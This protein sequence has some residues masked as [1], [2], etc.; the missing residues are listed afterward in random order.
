MKIKKINQSAG[1]VANV[2]DSLT[3]N[4]TTDALSAKQG[5]IL[6]EKIENI[7]VSG[8][9]TSIIDVDTLPAITDSNKNQIVRYQHKLYIAAEKYIGTP[10]DLGVGA[11][12]SSAKLVLS[13]PDTLYA[14]GYAGI[15]TLTFIRTE[16]SAISSYN[17]STNNYMSCISIGTHGLYGDKLY[18][19]NTNTQ[20]VAINLKSYIM[21]ANAGL[22]TEIKTLT[23]VTSTGFYANLGNYIKYIPATKVWL[24]IDS[25]IAIGNEEP[26]GQEVL[27]IDEDEVEE[28]DIDIENIVQ[29][30]KE[31][32]SG[33]VLYDNLS[34]TMES[35]TLTE[36][37]RNFEY[38]EIFAFRG[39]RAFS[40]KI[41]THLDYILLNHQRIVSDSTYIYVKEFLI[42]DNILQKMYSQFAVMTPSDH[43]G[44][45]ITDDDAICVTKVIGH[46]RLP[47]KLIKFTVDDITYFAHEGMTWEQ[48]INSSY[49]NGSFTIDGTRV[50]YNTNAYIGIPDGTGALQRVVVS[51]DTLLSN[52]LYKSFYSSSPMPS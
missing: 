2:I 33:T 15:G 37:A 6:D 10:Q 8:G 26:I 14:S 18:S 12:L 21:P 7:S 11:N 27:W 22:I 3:S 19:A 35:I 13:F 39:N 20:E 17:G 30:V 28:D 41:Q 46:N 40:T 24:P 31:S 51:S 1:V 32:L 49:N 50:Y 48:F 16:N 43:S 9:T 45:Y 36:S 38:L 44:D 25:E 47:F 52:Q 5:K 23:E 34:G 29:R 42:Q 4:S